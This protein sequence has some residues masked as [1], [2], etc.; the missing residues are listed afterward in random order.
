MN[1][2]SSGLAFNFMLNLGEERRGKTTLIVG[3]LSL[4]LAG[5]GILVESNP[6]MRLKTTSGAIDI[7]VAKEGLGCHV[8]KYGYRLKVKFKLLYCTPVQGF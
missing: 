5:A 4:A 6:P 7:T 1:S 2:Y 3:V 8:L